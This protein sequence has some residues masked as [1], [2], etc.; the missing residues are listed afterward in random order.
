MKWER[1]SEFFKDDD[2]LRCVAVPR[3]VKVCNPVDVLI[4]EVFR[5]E[6]C[7]SSPGGAGDVADLNIT[8][9]VRPTV[10]GEHGT[11]F[12][13]HAL[14]AHEGYRV[15]VED[16]NIG[17]TVFYVRSQI[18][19]VKALPILDPFSEGNRSEDLTGGFILILALFHGI[20][21]GLLSGSLFG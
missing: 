4:A 11:G 6:R 12:P 14:M 19:K 18:F 1:L 15:S 20:I 5:Y 13:Y 10:V 17:L 8:I 9:D 2:I 7:F 21:P 16:F 3:I